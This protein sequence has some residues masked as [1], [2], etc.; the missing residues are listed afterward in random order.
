MKYV[1]LI[2]LFLCLISTLQSQT[3]IV[4]GACFDAPIVLNPGPIINDKPSYSGVGSVLSTPGVPVDLFWDNATPA[5]FLMFGGQPIFINTDDTDLPPDTDAGSW[6]LTGA[7][8]CTGGDP[9]RMS[10]A[11]TF[12]VEW[13]YFKGRR[14][15]DQSVSL[16]WQTASETNNE[17]FYI[18]KSHDGRTFEQIDFLKGSGTSAETHDYSYTDTEAERGKIYYRLRQADFDGTVSYS[19]IIVVQGE[20]E[21]VSVFPNPIQDEL[22]IILHESESSLAFVRDVT[23]K[24]IMEIQLSEG[25]NSISL[26]KLSSGVYFLSINVE[27]EMETI[28]IVKE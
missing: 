21:M 12:P 9:F 6:P 7:I 25:R 13:T 17:G 3:V 11:G 23:G 5:W 2:T 14:N 4:E 20:K 19:N 26:S 16:F 24:S 18:E 28:R 1:L 27:D 8:P 22:Q 15:K 10:G